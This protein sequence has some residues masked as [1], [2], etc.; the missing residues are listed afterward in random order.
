MKIEYAVPCR[1]IE[2][3]VGGTF[4]IIGAETNAPVVP[5]LPQQLPTLL[6]VCI[7]QSFAESPD[8]ELRIRVL[9]PS[10]EPCADELGVG[11][12]MERSPLLPQGWSNRILIPAMVMF[13]ADAYGGYSME[14]STGASSLSVP[15][16]VVDPGA[17]AP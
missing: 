5:S 6:L 1:G 2:A 9:N 11:F 8:G 14:L 16:L 13:M 15:I 10:M 4:L 17:S 7:S 3:L 12:R